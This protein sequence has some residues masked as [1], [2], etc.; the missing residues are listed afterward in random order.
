MGVTMIFLILSWLY[1][2]FMA[3][4]S[5][6]ALSRHPAFSSSS[7]SLALRT[8]SF[9]LASS[10]ADFSSFLRHFPIFPSSFSSFSI[11]SCTY[12]PYFPFLIF[13]ISSVL[14]PFSPFILCSFSSFFLSSFSYVFPILPLL[15]FASS[16]PHFPHL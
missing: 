13:L 14:F 8:H 1:N 2:V 16:H 9:F 6:V 12:F 4:Y 7:R 11:F 3:C 5:T 15:I 10:S